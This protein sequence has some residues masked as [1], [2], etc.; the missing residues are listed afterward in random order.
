MHEVGQ[1]R[2]GEKAV[3]NWRFERRFTASTL[4]VNVDPLM[5][6][7][8]IS[9]LLDALLRDVKPVSNGNFLADESFESFRRVEDVFGHSFVFTA[10]N[11]K[12]AKEE[13]A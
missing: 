12:D 10:K 7:G 9:E 8:G 5:V 6:K 1:Q 11:A 13:D 2:Q 3:R 4:N